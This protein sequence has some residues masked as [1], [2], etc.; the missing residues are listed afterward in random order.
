[1]YRGGGRAAGA[2]PGQ[3]WPRVLRYT[4]NIGQE[5]PDTEGVRLE[6]IRRYLERK[7]G[8]PVE[9]W[10]SS[11]YGVTIEAFRARKIEASTLGPF[12]YVIGAER[13]SIEAMVT[14]GKPT[15]EPLQYSGTLT[16]PAS[17]K[18]LSIDDV[19]RHSH[20]LTVSFVDPASTSG[21][22]VQRACFG[23][24]GIEPDRDF[25]KVV[26]A[27]DHPTSALMA[28]ARKVD[29]AA[30]GDTALVGLIKSGKVRADELRTIWTSPPIPETLVAVRKDLPPAFK[31]R[32][33][34]AM[35]DM[36]AEAPGAYSNTAPKVF[37]ERY[38][39]TKFV[40]AT[41]ATYDPV[42][43]LA[44]GARHLDLPK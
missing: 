34:Q 36:A 13:A 41:D 30:I 15:G 39:N 21:N 35:L 16:V 7:L 14:R 22:L 31:R 4:I 40:V 17:S 20:D 3:D 25:K 10:G 9:V 23:S 28:V 33:Q 5:N 42:R 8:M 1:M 19:V 38:R 32:L 29:V 11:G 24:L 12:A 27:M 26:Y 2:G 43:K 37:M 44:K 6:P 18:L